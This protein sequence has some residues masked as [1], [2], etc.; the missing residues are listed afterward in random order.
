MFKKYSNFKNLHELRADL[1]LILSDI[2]NKDASELLEF[3][4]ATLSN[5]FTEAK[6]YSLNNKILNGK[7]PPTLDDYIITKNGIL[8]TTMSD[9]FQLFYMKDIYQGRTNPT[10]GEY[11]G[12]KMGGSVI[13][14]AHIKKTSTN[15]YKVYLDYAVLS[16]LSKQTMR[17]LLIATGL[18]LADYK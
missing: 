8:R 12:I 14:T 1:D 3:P 10:E 15:K 2:N 5:D 6:K 16:K 13:P 4:Y 17:R 7:F 11:F 18:K 9:S